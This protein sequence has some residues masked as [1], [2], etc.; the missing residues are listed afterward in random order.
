M[1]LRRG[2]LWSPIL[3]IVVAAVLVAGCGQ[4]AADQGGGTGGPAVNARPQ[5]GPGRAGQT[6][7]QMIDASVGWA[8]TGDSVLRTTDGG[9]HWLA[10]TPD[11]GQLAPGAGEGF[12]QAC[13]L[14][15]DTALFARSEGADAR[16]VT[17]Y[18]TSDGGATWAKTSIGTAPDDV[19]TPR[20]I[21]FSGEDNGWLLV[22]F[23]GVAM[24]SEMV[25]IYTTGDGGATWRP[26]AVTEPTGQQSGSLPL[27]GIKSGVT[28]LSDQIGW[29][30]GAWHGDGVWLYGTF[31]G[32]RTWQR[33]NLPVPRGYS[34]EGGAVSTYAPVFFSSNGFV[35]AVFSPER[36]L[37]FFATTDGGL[38]WKATTPVPSG[39]DATGFVWAFTDALHGWLSDGQRIYAA[40]DG[41]V[42]WHELKADQRLT[43]LVQ[44]GFRIVELDFVDDA[45]GFA[46]L[47]SGPADGT[48]ALL[49]TTDGGLTWSE[50]A[51]PEATG[52]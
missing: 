34:T 31:D 40:T 1:R 25:G 35:P 48:R 47:Q 30:A 4:P 50:C 41:C 28:F 10:V 3:M 39:N 18:S 6:A 13:V 15:P 19:P 24:G 11:V 45:N 2:C 9:A 52:E 49:K 27:G 29:V 37:V 14:G 51:A 16:E 23:G 44:S 8:I 43:G 38:S 26:A 12:G 33:A 42:T 5:W 22:N 21:G 46:L 32:G 36:S 20:A 7:V 17:L